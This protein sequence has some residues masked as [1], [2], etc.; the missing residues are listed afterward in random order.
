MLMINNTYKLPNHRRIVIKAD[1][2]TPAQ[3]RKAFRNARAS[4]S[5]EG[6][7]FTARDNRFLLERSLSRM[8]QSEFVKQ[9]KE[10]M[11]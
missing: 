7:Q 8:P 2:Y 11:F 3:I 6:F 5:I 1:T 9:A 10:L 4:V